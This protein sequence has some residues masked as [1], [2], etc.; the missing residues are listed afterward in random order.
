[1]QRLVFHR[2]VLVV[3]MRCGASPQRSS[4]LTT[5]FDVVQSEPAPERSPILS[6]R[7]P[8]L[9]LKMSTCQW[10]PLPFFTKAESSK[11]KVCRDF[12]Q[13]TRRGDKAISRI[14][15]IVTVNVAN[16]SASSIFQTQRNYTRTHI[17]VHIAVEQWPAEGELVLAGLQEYM[18]VEEGWMA[19]VKTFVVRPT[20]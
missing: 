17:S 12:K 6:H 13:S 5:R 7:L 19:A 20:Q 9:V 18:R 11:V 3:L 15:P 14:L 2:F 4:L 1:M 8:R 10:S 16:K